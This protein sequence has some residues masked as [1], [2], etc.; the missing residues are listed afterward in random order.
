MFC[1]HRDLTRKQKTRRR[2]IPDATGS[3]VN[4]EQSEANSELR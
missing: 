3:E 4:K 2:H 1:M